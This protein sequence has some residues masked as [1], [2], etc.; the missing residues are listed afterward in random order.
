MG[1]YSI[2]HCHTELSSGVTNIDSVT[3]Y[4]QY[5]ERAKNKNEG[6]RNIIFT[7]HGN[8]F[9]WYKKKLAL[10]EAGFKYAHAIEIYV[11]EDININLR[12][13]FHTILIAKNYEGFKE[14]NTLISMSFNRANVLCHG[15]EKHFYY[16]PR[17]SFEELINTSDNIIVLTACMAGILSKGHKE[18]KKR[19]LQFLIQNKER[20]YLEVQHHNCEEQAEYNKKLAILSHKY[21]I[22]LIACTDTHSLNETHAKGREILQKA[23]GVYF[24]NEAN[25]DLV[26]KTYDELVAAFKSQG[27]LSE[28]SRTARTAVRS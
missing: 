17:I 18:L 26:Y 6:I 13:N 11:T 12:D 3:K 21:H 16:M 22:P 4:G 9:N 2:L 27:A 23:K 25:W 20:C 24:E 1:T 5:I 19:F 28:N 15:T 14:L 10:E 7:E 8:V